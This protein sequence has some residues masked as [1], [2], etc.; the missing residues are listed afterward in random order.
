MYGKR[1]EIVMFIGKRRIFTLIELLVV[2]AIIAILAGMLLP[3]LN[4]A[5]EKARAIACLNNQKQIGQ[6]NFLYVNDYNDYLIPVNT[7]D[8]YWW[9][10]LLV[11]EQL[12]LDMNWSRMD[13]EG[14]K[15]KLIKCPSTTFMS[16][17]G[18]AS[19]TPGVGL[20]NYGYN[21]HVSGSYQYNGTNIGKSTKIS[22]ISQGSSRPLIADYSNEIAGFHL[23]HWVDEY[24]NTMKFFGRHSKRVNIMY[25]DGHAAQVDFWGNRQELSDRTPLTSADPNYVE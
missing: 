8:G 17:G 23:W 25:V 13:S 16:N 22:A 1:K 11:N 7:I 18:S 14:Q 3:A 20:T 5:R 15:S 10:H 24:T 9:P 12:H 4:T 21:I 19:T 2:I 6:I